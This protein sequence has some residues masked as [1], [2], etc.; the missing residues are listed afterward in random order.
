[1]LTLL[2]FGVFWFSPYSWRVIGVL[3]DEPFYQGMPSSYWR[4]EIISRHVESDDESKAG[5]WFHDLIRLVPHKE[6]AQLGIL[7]NDPDAL[8]VVLRLMVDSDYRVRQWASNYL[9]HYWAFSDEVLPALLNGTKD[10]DRIVQVN[11]LAG[12]NNY[13]FM[14]KNKLN[15]DNAVPFILPFLDDT[16]LAVR[17]VAERALRVAAPAE[18]QKRGL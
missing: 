8:S 1:M 10:E 3:R 5:G 15:A 12:I 18:A 6:K 11:S 2:L 17:D 16:N 7:G 9:S 13:F 4:G 14:H